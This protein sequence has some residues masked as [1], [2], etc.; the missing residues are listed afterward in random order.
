MNVSKQTLVALAIAAAF[1]GLSACGGGDDQGSVAKAPDYGSDLAGAPK[2]LA[3]LHK[4]ENELLGGGTEAFDARLREL[5]GY[6]IV[7]NKWASWCGPCRAEYPHF[8]S[9]AAKRGDQ[10]AFVGIDSNDGE[11]SAR[12]FLE[13]FPVPYPS[14]LDPDLKIA[15]SIEGALAFPATA[16]YD[17]KGE[18]AYVKNG[19]YADEEELAA[20]I[21]R[22]AQ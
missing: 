4:Q 1:A 14:Y 3:A 19:V 7:V 9:Q 10:V 13:E 22:Y 15:D 21:R 20:D 8:Q 17:S 2:P 6:P 16:F 18:L 12:D 5:R 11:S